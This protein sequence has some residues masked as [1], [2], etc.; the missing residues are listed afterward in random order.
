MYCTVDNSIWQPHNVSN[1]QRIY[2][3]IV[4]IYAI[5][6]SDPSLQKATVSTH[7]HYTVFTK[8]AIYITV[9]VYPRVVLG[10]ICSTLS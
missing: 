1:L 5:D 7:I 6:F 4:C 9:C 8:V 10:Q 3:C 2:N